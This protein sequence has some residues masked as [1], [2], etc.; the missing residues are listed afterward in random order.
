MPSPAS[1]ATFIGARPASA[2]KPR[3][4]LAMARLERAD[5]VRVLKREPDLVEAVQQAVLGEGID[6]ET[7]ALAA[8]RGDRLCVKVDG[9]PITG[10][11]LHLAKQAIDDLQIEPDQE[12]AVLQ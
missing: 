6:V 4:A 8:R 10:R 1:T 9:D 2:E 7:V 11:A 3:L 12:Q 5:P